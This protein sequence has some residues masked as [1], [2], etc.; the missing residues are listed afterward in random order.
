M[1]QEAK[2]RAKQEGD[3]TPVLKQRIADLEAEV[4]A[5][6]SMRVDLEGSLSIAQAQLRAAPGKNPKHYDDILLAGLRK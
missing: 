5:E 2:P 3:N 4:Q 6:R 1:N